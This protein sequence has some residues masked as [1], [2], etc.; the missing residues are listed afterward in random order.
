MYFLFAQADW[1]MVYHTT[2]PAPTKRE[3]FEWQFSIK[4]KSHWNSFNKEY[5]SEFIQD[6][7]RRW[8]KKKERIVEKLG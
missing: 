1:Y 5:T 2:K 4:K 3:T 8:M 7:E 6:H